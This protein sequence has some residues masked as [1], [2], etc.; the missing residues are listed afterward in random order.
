[1]VA[2]NHPEV[3]QLAESFLTELVG[4]PVRQHCDTTGSPQ[5]SFIVLPPSP[6]TPA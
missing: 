5:C 2:P 3:C 6:E 4:V 1:V